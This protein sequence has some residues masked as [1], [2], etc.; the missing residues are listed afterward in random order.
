MHLTVVKSG[1]ELSRAWNHDGRNRLG[2][3]HMSGAIHQ[4]VT[5]HDS[6]DFELSYPVRGFDLD[7]HVAR[8]YLLPHFSTKRSVP[9]V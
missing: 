9:H 1:G 2:R 6:P 3:R 7:F 4:R 8:G 5:S